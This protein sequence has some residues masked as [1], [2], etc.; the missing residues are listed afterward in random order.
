MTSVTIN[1]QVHNQSIKSK[2]T[3][4]PLLNTNLL[5]TGIKVKRFDL[6]V[7]DV[8]LDQKWSYIKQS[9]KVY[10]NGISVGTN[11]SVGFYK[12]PLPNPPAEFALCSLVGTLD[13]GKTYFPIGTHLKM[14]N[15]WPDLD[16]IQGSPLSLICWGADSHISE[17]EIKATV[18]VQEQFAIK[19]L[20][21]GP[22]YEELYETET[23]FDIHAYHHSVS[24]GEA[25]NTNIQLEP[26]DLLKVGVHPKDLYNMQ[27]NDSGFYINANGL[28]YETKKPCWSAEPTKGSFKFVC[29]SLIGAIGK[30]KDKAIDNVIH[31]VIDDKDSTY[32]PIGTHLEM[33][34][35]N[36]GTLFFYCWDVDN[37]NNLGS[38]KAFVK[39]VRQ[40]R[41]ISPVLL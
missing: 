26:G 10:A 28:N 16:S 7:I 14:I 40:V 19:E 27:N 1:A 20:E 12:D 36:R 9:Q 25:L 32:F 13:D 18:S 5:E 11:Q 31:K 23:S 35:L 21:S 29:G 34:V 3:R 30:V 17:G 33:T 41:Y 6:L 37:V 22:Q 8:N 39:V 2:S 24:G 38:V 4:T 15:L